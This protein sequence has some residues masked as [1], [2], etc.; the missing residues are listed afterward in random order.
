ML[1]ASVRNVAKHY[2][3]HTVLSQVSF[4]LRAG[5]HVALIGPN[6]TGK[7]TLLRILTGQEA[8]DGGEVEFPTGASVGYLEQHPTFSAEDTV[9]SVAVAALGDVPQLIPQIEELT[10]R[11]ASVDQHSPEHAQLLQQYDHLQVRLSQTD[12]YQWEQRVHRTLTGLG[13]AAESFHRPVAQLSGG[14]QNRLMLASLLLQEPDLMILDE[15]DNHLDIESTEWLEQ[16]LANWPGAFLVVSHDRLFLDRT[17]NSVLELLHGSVDRYRGNYSAYLRQKAERLEVQR[18]TY[19][20]NCEEIAKLEDFIRRHHHGQKAAQAEDRRKKLERIERVPPPREIATPKFRFPPASRSGDIVL[21]A[22]G[23]SKA[24]DRVL[25]QDV[26]LQIERGQRWAILGSNG[27]GKS[28]LLKCLLGLV[29]P[30]AGT[31]ELGHH[32]KIGYFDQLLANLPPET[33]A[34]EAIRVQHRDLDDLARRNLLGSF[35]ISGDTALRPI[36]SLSGGERN[37]VMLAWLSAMEANVLVLDEPTN[38]LDVWSREALEQALRRF[39]GTV[40]LVTHDRYLVNA[41]ADHLLVINNGRVSQVVGNYDTYQHW[42]REGLAVEDRGT[43][44]AKKASDAGSSRKNGRD[45]SSP[46]S[47]SATPV[48]GTAAAHREQKR[49]QRRRR[50]YPYRKVEDLE[51]EIVEVESQIETRQAEMLLPEVLRDGLRMKAIHEQIQALE[52]RLEQLYEH[53]E[54]A[55][56]LN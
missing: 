32:L 47:T 39:D 49:R 14:Q 43:V 28:T 54:E 2:G 24:Y 52:S 42:V 22:H 37:R 12:A 44:G 15:P 56:E 26:S 20:K 29:P 46:A 7:T 10:Q 3:D 31:V 36:S 21:T 27:S 13:F 9:W 17:T 34:A 8:P 33:T 35:G 53:Y 1:L 5:D 18:R 40:L 38:H 55:V 51:Q 25:F 19:E 30:D 50:K 6:G 41:V 45:G 11:L 48:D 16:T 23:L 4:D